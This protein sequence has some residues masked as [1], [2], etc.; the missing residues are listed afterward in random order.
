MRILLRSDAKFQTLTKV[1]SFSSKNHEVVNKIFDKLHNQK[2]MKWAENHTLSDYS[3]FV[4]WQD[5]LID[6]KITKKKQIII[7]FKN[8][9]KITKSDIYSILLQTNIIQA[10]AEYSYISV[11]DAVSFFYQ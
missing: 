10:I 6:S 3:I 9:N 8:L 11:L 5:A 1:Y 7:D 4:V 2:H